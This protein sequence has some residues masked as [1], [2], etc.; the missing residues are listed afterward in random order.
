MMDGMDP[1][2]RRELTL[3][4]TGFIFVLGSCIGS[5]LNV[6]IW[7]LPRGESLSYP[8]SHCPKCGHPLAA[9]QNVPL[10]GWLV[11]RGRCFYCKAPVSVRY[12][13]VELFTALLF[14]AVW[15]GIVHA[16]LPWASAARYLFMAGALLAAAVIDAEHGIIP[17]KITGAGILAALL[18]AALL[19]ASAFFP[20]CMPEGDAALAATL[21][22]VPEAWLQPGTRGFALLSSLLGMVAGAGFLAVAR[23]AG[24]LFM[25]TQSLPLP[26][27][28]TAIALGPG[29]LGIGGDAPVAVDSLIGPR[30]EACELRMT[31]GRLAWRSEAGEQSRE[32]R[33]ENVRVER[34]GVEAGDLFVPTADLLRLEGKASRIRR[35]REVLGLG[36]VKLMAMTGAFLG[37]LAILWVILLSA[38]AATA[39]GCALLPFRKSRGISLRYGPY[40]AAA[41]L[42]V[43]FFG[44]D[45]VLLYAHVILGSFFR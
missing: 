10:L 39:A 30:H 6:V 3:V 25:G 23:T 32:L 29:G 33:R 13:I 27:P 14:T 12:P 5:F 7:R 41:G 22:F 37:P 15:L 17:D 11:L 34:D 4:V 19:P 38:L 21:P 35:S 44:N 31:E 40:I 2:I 16:G 24:T 26:E 1:E 42:A 36:D 8:A 28:E 18:A 43:F 20:G 9:W 45:L